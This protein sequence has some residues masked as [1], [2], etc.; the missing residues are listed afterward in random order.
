MIIL[1]S[2]DGKTITALDVPSDI[3]SEL[4]RYLAPGVVMVA[5][6]GAESQHAMTVGVNPLPAE[7]PRPALQL[8]EDDPKE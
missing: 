8:C 6:C 4:G 7:A 5:T 3:Q 1:I 2:S